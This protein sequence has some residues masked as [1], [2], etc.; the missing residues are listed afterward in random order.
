MLI[1][2]FN[3]DKSKRLWLVISMAVC[4]A[5]LL[6]IISFFY[7]YGGK[8]GNVG[9]KDE[10]FKLKGYYAEYDLT[11]FSNK[12]QNTYHMK[13]WY[14]NDNLNE[15]FRFD[16]KP[17]NS[18]EISY[19]LTDNML[20]I[21]SNTQISKFNIDEYS[22]TKRN[23]TSFSTFISVYNQVLNQNE[24]NFVK[25][26]KKTIDNKLHYIMEINKEKNR[27]NKL[28]EEFDFLFDDGLNIKKIE[29]VVDNT[30]NIPE[31]Y[32]IFTYDNKI[33]FGIKYIKFDII[34]KFDD[35]TFANLNK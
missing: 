24:D 22:I 14:F 7:V 3:I 12:N 17:N 6:I 10:I 5:A 25:L 35:K 20:S 27:E 23:L 34:D 8:K 11:V 9:N 4:I 31:E 13:E 1:K 15:K 16:F 26:E 33:M 32:Y 30:K 18:D 2:T 21:N 19:I 28:L 29:L